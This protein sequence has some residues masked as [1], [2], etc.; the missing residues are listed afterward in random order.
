MRVGVVG[1][2][3]LGTALRLA[4]RSAGHTVTLLR[5]PQ[6]TPNDQSPL[7]EAILDPI[8]QWKDFDFLLLAFRKK[9]SFIAELECDEGLL[10][11]RRIPNSISIASVVLSPATA[12]LDA[13]LPDHRIAHFVTTPAPQ[14][15]GAIALLPRS[16][17]D[18][19]GLRAAF[20]GLHW[21]QVDEEAQ[22][23]LSFLMIGS[24]IAAAS[25]A[26]PS[27]ML[28]N[29]LSSTEVEYLQHVLGDA[30]RIMHLSSGT[31]SRRSPC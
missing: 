24:G 30:K 9:A 1:R 5:Q 19:A 21:I 14:L 20:S 18:T 6:S 17:I 12:P 31:G 26:H 11:L 15:S 13:F 16:A 29:D 23:R 4:A 3:R 10:Q 7:T 25:L 2:G 28:G 22:V 27:K 8:L